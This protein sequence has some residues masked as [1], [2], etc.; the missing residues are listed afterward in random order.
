MFMS[1][2][3]AHRKQKDPPEGRVASGR[4]RLRAPRCR[5][6]PAERDVGLLRKRA[7]NPQPGAA[8]HLVCS[9]P[10]A[11]GTR[12]AS[13]PGPFVSPKPPGA[14]SGWLALPLPSA[15]QEEPPGRGGGGCSAGFPEAAPGQ[16]SGSQ[17]G[18]KSPT[19]A[20]SSPGGAHGGGAG[21]T[22]CK[23]NKKAGGNRLRVCRLATH[24]SQNPRCTPFFGGK[25]G[26]RGR[27]G[28]AG[29][30]SYLR[31]NCRWRL[32]LFQN[33]KSSQ[34]KKKKLSKHKKRIAREHL[35]WSGQQH[36]QQQQEEKDR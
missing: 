31:F 26:G 24:G 14:R 13:S 17:T 25:G 16:P 6:L 10:G 12:C 19:L 1:V 32:R 23:P 20:S 30:G 3:I 33:R 35:T 34:K 2:G 11:G 27:E 21:S 22:R 9:E 7:R 36:G 18:R 4:A 5:G 8:G 29:E 28:A 15:G